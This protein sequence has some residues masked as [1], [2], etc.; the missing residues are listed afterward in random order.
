MKT[1]S[2]I[3]IATSLAWL[4]TGGIAF[5]AD[6]H[7]EHAADQRLAINVDAEAKEHVLLEMRQLLE[8]VHHVLNGALKKDM[9]AVATHA[10]AVGLKAMRA[11]P[12]SIANQLPKEFKM[13]GRGVHEAMDNIARDAKDMGDSQHTIEQVNTML[14]SCVSCH[15]TFKLK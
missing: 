9:K 13:M 14:G 4:S 6:P 11:T 10:E 12:A 1:T 3:A 8:T 7:T 2:K 15:A 5:A